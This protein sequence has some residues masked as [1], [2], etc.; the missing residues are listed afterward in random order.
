MLVFASALAAIAALPPDLRTTDRPPAP[1]TVL[2]PVVCQT[3]VLPRSGWR[4]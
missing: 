2:A 3:V 4:R 1:P